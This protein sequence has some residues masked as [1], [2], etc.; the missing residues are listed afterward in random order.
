MSITM[1][2]RRFWTVALLSASVISLEVLWTRI[3]SAE[4][5]YTFAF[6]ILSFAVLGLG[7]GALALRLV[8]PLD[9]DENCGTVLLLSCVSGLLGPWLVLRLGLEFGKIVKEPVMAVKLIA[10]LLIVAA[11]YF[12]AGAALAK[13]FKSDSREMPRLYMWDLLGAGLGAAL[14]VLAMNTVGV[15]IAAALACLPLAVASSLASGRFRLAHAALL[16]LVGVVALFSG[17]MLD[18]S[19]K[20]L[21]P[22]IYR[23]WDTMGLLK[24]H[25]MAMDYMNINI[26]N[27][28]N[29]PVILFD[30]D[31][32]GKM[33]KEMEFAFF[34]KPLVGG[35]SDFVLCS[36][37]AGGGSEVLQGLI[38]GAGEIHA[39]EVNPAINRMLTGGFLKEFTGRIYLDPKVKV[40]SE[41]GRAYLRRYSGKFD[42]IVASSSNTFA[43]T[44]SGALAL[45][46]NYLF[47]TQAFG[48]YWRALRPDGHMIMEHQFYI[49]RAVGE[50][51]AAMRLAGVGRPEDHIAVYEL[52][53]RRRMVL[54]LSRKPITQDAIQGLFGPLLP[55][56]EDVRLLY[57]ETDATR[58]S[59]V[60]RVI[61]EGWEKVSASSPT[62]ISPCGDDR[63]F[64]AQMGLWKNL[65]RK[66]LDKISG[67]EI[68]GFPLAKLI[69]VV[70]LGLASLLGL[71]LLLIPA[72][73]NRGRKL[74]AVP[75]L[76]FFSI[77]LAFMAVEVV[78]I[79]QFTL[80]IGSSAYTLVII[81]PTLL[82]A[83]GV[84]SLYSSR[85]SDWA[86]FVAVLLWLA[87]DI[88]FFHDVVAV[89]GGLGAG[90]R[91]LVAIAL[92]APLGFFMGMPFPKAALRVREGIDWGF[93]VNGV[94]S[95]LGSAAVLLLAMGA[96]FRVALAA[97]G[98]FYLL[99]LLLLAAKGCWQRAEFKAT[100]F[101]T[102]GP[103]WS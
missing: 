15:P 52:P 50:S 45:A 78:L 46:E 85:I 13:I 5:F 39:V 53:Q 84:G 2:E 62:D 97:A 93:A 77:G 83:S 66:K 23:R 91:A 29:T 31:L 36:L 75:W 57:P 12:F 71:P 101:L 19:R 95:V 79:Q 38:E 35:K 11:P 54:L 56:R 89:A 88:M 17:A 16:A 8:P 72:L 86:P 80:L 64:V 6:L 1:F 47:T 34:F 25:D 27:A 96:G 42:I 10:A 74:G 30:G 28:A 9:R 21:G 98:A 102:A 22:I 33:A 3:F 76:Y 65:D 103:D 60:V 37:G 48:D 99:A 61:R 68:S 67:M 32:G 14:C 4:F 41:D 94:S 43:A 7:L 51:I 44:A 59:T 63:P 20:E 70:I 49:P 26:D 81:L 58:G 69:L 73:F 40:V 24:V 55:D 100:S 90:G 92:L 18:T 82:L 87:M